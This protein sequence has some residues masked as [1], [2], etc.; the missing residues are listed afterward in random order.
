MHATLYI[1]R[2]HL[3]PIPSP[4]TRLL[5]SVDLTHIR[6]SMPALLHAH[7][8]LPPPWS[9]LRALH[10]A[11]KRCIKATAAHPLPARRRGRDRRGRS[12]LR[13]LPGSGPPPAATTP[14][15]RQRALRDGSSHGPGR[16]GRGL[17]ALPGILRARLIPFF[18][19]SPFPF[20]F[21]PFSFTPFPSSLAFSPSSFSLSLLP[22][23]IFPHSLIPFLLFNFPFFSIS[24]PFFPFFSFSSLF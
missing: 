19:L 14:S 4:I 20:F 16:A 15:C 1:R 2:F 5:T 24:F 21:F 23:L 7:P 3:S 10:V 18:P 9:G 22:F 6:S 8:S 17:P 12:G 11:D 13:L